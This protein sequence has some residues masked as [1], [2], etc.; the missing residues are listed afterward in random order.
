MPSYDWKLP[1]NLPLCF[2]SDSLY[3]SAQ[4]AIFSRI[5]ETTLPEFYEA[6]QTLLLLLRQELEQDMPPIHYAAQ[7]GTHICLDKVYLEASMRLKFLALQAVPP[8]LPAPKSEEL[9]P[10]E[11]VNQLTDTINTSPPETYLGTDDQTPNTGS[12]R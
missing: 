8:P 2:F 6:A 5:S 1:T 10:E 7:F 4:D 11:V 12:D 3:R 9:T